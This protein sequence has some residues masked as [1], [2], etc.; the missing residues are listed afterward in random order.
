MPL[1]ENLENIYLVNLL[2][3]VKSES[4]TIAILE[5]LERCFMSCYFLKKAMQVAGTPND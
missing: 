1:L 4:K 5:K 3:K 2:L